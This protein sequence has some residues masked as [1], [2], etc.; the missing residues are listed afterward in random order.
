MKTPREERGLP[1]LRVF[2]LAAAGVHLAIVALL[3]SAKR[4]AASSSEAIHLAPGDLV[5]V[6]VAP[7]QPDPFPPSPLPGGGSPE[8]RHAKE[9]AS[10]ARAQLALPKAT[11][12]PAGLPP[13]LPSSSVTE[14]TGVTPGPVAD[15]SAAPAVAAPAS[16]DA[17]AASGSGDGANGGPGGAG[18][19][20][21]T[22]HVSKAIRGSNAFGNGTHGA[23]TGR[24]CFLPVGTLRISA[25]T[26]C[27][28]VATVY[29]DSLDIPER[30][31]YDGF[32]GV[33]DRSDWFLIDYTGSFITTTSGPYEFRLHSDDGSYLYVD[34]Q[35]VI[36]NDGKHAPA[37]RSGTI[38]L[39][40]GTHSIKV[41][42]AQTTDRMALQL[43]VRT[44]RATDERIFTTRL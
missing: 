15:A 41:R 9:G 44:P 14:E 26:S 23:L 29:A 5:N 31:F 24:V 38:S 43:F 1:P 37:S 30:H 36:E 6:D 39:V 21:G 34:N 19:G 10:L 17:S 33:S 3:S 22:R 32:P 25:V 12:A 4:V 16:D 18:R 35:L 11:P 27:E 2:L 20:S 8:V 40:A 28:Y 42:Y 7:S 13:P